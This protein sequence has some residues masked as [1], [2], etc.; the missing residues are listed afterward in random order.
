MLDF[1]DHC[2][3]VHG[4]AFECTYTCCCVFRFRY[5]LGG[6]TWVEYWPVPAECQRAEFRATCVGINEMEQQF[7]IFGCPNK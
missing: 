6:T 5:V 4:E 2:S 7:T 1:K 3:D